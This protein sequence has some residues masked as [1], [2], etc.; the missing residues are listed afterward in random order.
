MATR[1][2]FEDDQLKAI[3]ERLTTLAT[4]AIDHTASLTRLA[5]SKAD[6]QAEIDEAQ[7]GVEALQEE[8]KAY[9]EDLED[10]NRE[11]DD[12]KR[13]ASKANKALDKA[14]KDIAAKVRSLLCLRCPVSI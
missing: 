2:K 5:T 3:E 1:T 7:S 14:L 8:L 10:K 6:A 13:T 11:L 9:L 4:T 12:V